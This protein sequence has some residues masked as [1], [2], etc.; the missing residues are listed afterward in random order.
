MQH[1]LSRTRYK[2]CPRQVNGYDC[3]I[4]AVAVVLHLSECLPLITDTFSQGDVTKARFL[5]AKAFASSSSLMEGTCDG[6]RSC[7]PH[8]SIVKANHVEIMTPLQSMV[9]TSEGRFC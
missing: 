3:G 5:L 6:F 1:L 9:I 8:L 2:D 4:F 7:F